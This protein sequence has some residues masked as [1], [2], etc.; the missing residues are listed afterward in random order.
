MTPQNGFPDVSGASMV[1][2]GLRLRDL[3]LHNGM[4][5]R[6]AGRAATMSHTFI[7]NVEGGKSGI[8]FARLCRLANTYGVLVSDLLVGTH[9]EGM[10]PV[11]ADEGPE[12][13][14]V[15]GSVTLRYLAHSK[16]KIQP[17]TI[18]IKPL[19]RLGFFPQTPEKFVYCVHGKVMVDVAETRYEL[20]EGDMLYI[21]SH[22]THRLSNESQEEVLIVGAIERASFE[23]LKGEG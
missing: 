2:I 15:K 23:S 16:S 11:R 6:S 10:N 19:G 1:M 8:S 5:L 14:I 9:G 3:R 7:S 4:S 17:F 21:P 22:V 13:P 20:G 18:R 12:F